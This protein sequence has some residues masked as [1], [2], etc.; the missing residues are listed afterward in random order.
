MYGDIDYTTLANYSGRG[1]ITTCGVAAEAISRNYVVVRK[2]LTVAQHTRRAFLAAAAGLTV[3]GS[4]GIGWAD[5]AH[6]RPSGAESELDGLDVPE[7]K[8][9]SYS[10]HVRPFVTAWGK[11][12]EDW[13]PAFAAITQDMTATGGGRLIVPAGRYH[14]SGH[15]LFDL[16]VVSVHLRQGSHVELVGSPDVFLGAPLGFFGNAKPGEPIENRIQRDFAAVFGPGAI[17]YPAD[18]LQR[19]PHENGVAMSYI[20]TA[21]MD[22]VHVRHVPGKGVTAQFGCNR[23]IMRNCTIGVT[24]DSAVERNYRGQCSIVAQGGLSFDRR[25][26][27]D[28]LFTDVVVENNTVNSL[29]VRGVHAS[30][31]RDVKVTNNTLAPSWG[32]GLVLQGV[33]KAAV[34]NNVFAKTSAGVRA[35]DNIATTG[36]PLAEG[37]HE[38]AVILGNVAEPQLLGNQLGGHSH[39]HCVFSWTDPRYPHYPAGVAYARGNR[40]SQGSA[41]V[42]GG[43]PQWDAG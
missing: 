16:P 14:I 41:A 13:Y 37:E 32:A 27:S 22:G 43:A 7:F 29:S 2:R 20:K 3:A 25:T 9:T 31:C 38:D 17:G 15:V 6:S 23:I 42:F 4:A 28:A 12:V 19:Y 35:G 40:W 18:Q 33:A 11:T 26:A 1:Y 24:S 10:Q 39:R 30:Y 5:T 34:E 36:Y 21:I 8:L